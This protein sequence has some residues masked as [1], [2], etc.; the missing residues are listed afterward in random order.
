MSTRFLALYIVLLLLGQLCF[1]IPVGAG[2]LLTALLQVPCFF[3]MKR[4]PA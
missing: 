1:S 4:H 3:T 2:I